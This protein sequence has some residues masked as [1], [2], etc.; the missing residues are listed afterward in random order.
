MTRRTERTELLNRLCV[1][2]DAYGRR[3]S[4]DREASITIDRLLDHLAM[5]WDR[6]RVAP[7]PST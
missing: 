4:Y 7:D 2:R 5:V 3:G 1:L 6:A